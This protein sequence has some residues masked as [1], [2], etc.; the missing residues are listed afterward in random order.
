[1][2]VAAIK[3]LAKESPALKDPSGALLPDVVDV[4]EISI[5]IACSVIKQA[6]EEGLAREKDIPEN[7]AKL[8]EWVRAQMWE[9]QYRELKRVKAT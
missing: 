1:M 4:R 9:P 6:I 7:N 2:L 5:K 3:A 8:A